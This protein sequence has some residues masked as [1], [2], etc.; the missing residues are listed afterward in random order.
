MRPDDPTH[1]PLPQ[2]IPPR[3]DPYASDP[4]S[5]H[6]VCMTPSRRRATGTAARGSALLLTNVTKVVGLGLAINELAIREDAR[7]S[8][9]ALCAICVLGAQVVEDVALRIIDRFF[10]TGPT[11]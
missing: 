4:L 8:A 9:I 7:N 6:G 1:P 3:G 10:G 5:D 11:S 2:R